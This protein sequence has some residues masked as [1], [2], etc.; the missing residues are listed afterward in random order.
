MKIKSQVSILCK[1]QKRKELSRKHEGTKTRKNNDTKF[2]VHLDWNSTGPICPIPLVLDEQNSM[3]YFKVKQ[4]G[5]I[6]AACQ[7]E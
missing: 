3:L 1:A 6:Y 5:G 7:V 2:P 4:M